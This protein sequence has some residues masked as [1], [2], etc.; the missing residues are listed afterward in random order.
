M[1][2][3]VSKAVT[4]VAI[5][6]AVE[7][8]ET[9]PWIRSGELDL[10]RPASII[11]RHRESMER[12]LVVPEADGERVLDLTQAGASFVSLGG[13]RRLPRARQQP[14]RLSKG[15][16][17]KVTLEGHGPGRGCLVAR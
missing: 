14:W 1:L 4:G 5:M 16:C 9:D 15:P 17:W 12:Q 3:S 2:A 6:Q 10:G 7:A 8:A 11:R 13:L